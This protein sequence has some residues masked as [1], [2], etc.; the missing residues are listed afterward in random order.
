MKVSLISTVKDASGHVE[1]FVS[2]VA[3]PSDRRFRRA[4]VKPGRRKRHWQARLRALLVYATL[5]L[6]LSYGVYRTSSVAAAAHLLRVDRIV[7]RGNSRLSRGE[8]LAVL[9]GLRG[10]SLV[11][12]DLDRWRS[13]IGLR[14]P[15]DEDA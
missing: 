13:A 10:E 8:V 9:N 6:A 11:W 7:V 3:A 12:T 14:Y 15:G 1:E 2:S 4:H 5:G